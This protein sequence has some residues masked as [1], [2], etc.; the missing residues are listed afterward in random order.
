MVE[1]FLK[2]SPRSAHDAEQ[3][4]GADICELAL[5]GDQVACV[6]VARE[7]R[8]LAIGIAKLATLFAPEIVVLGGGIMRSADLLP[9]AIRA[10]VRQTRRRIPEDRVRVV[11]SALADDAAL[12]GAAVVWLSR[13]PAAH[14]ESR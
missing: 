13:P 10:Q 3:L 1:R 4:T 12:I 2:S 5:C 9:P 8:Y 14:R 6:E 7:A 11:T